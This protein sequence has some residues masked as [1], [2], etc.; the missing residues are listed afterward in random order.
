MTLMGQTHSLPQLLPKPWLWG[1][2]P[3]LPSPS[4]KSESGKNPWSLEVENTH[5]DERLLSVGEGREHSSFGPHRLYKYVVK[6][7]ADVC[8][9][10]LVISRLTEEHLLCR[11]W[12]SAHT[13]VYA[14]KTMKAGAATPEGPTVCLQLGLQVR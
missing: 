1:L 4:C 11:T 6:S 14:N 7:L 8:L 9:R 5:N 13:W 12:C 3:P 10:I 2:L